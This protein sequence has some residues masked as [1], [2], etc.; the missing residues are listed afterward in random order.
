[1]NNHRFILQ[2]Y[3][4]GAEAV[5]V[6]LRAT[7]NAVLVA[8]STPRNKSRYLMMSADATMSRVAATISR[9]RNTLSV[10][11]RRSHYTPISQL[12]QHGEPSRPSSERRHR[13][14]RQR[15][16][17]RLCTDMRRTT[18]IFSSAPSSEPRMP[19]G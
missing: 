1:M 12:R 14:S 4:G 3:K 2:P 16:L 7:R 11:R 8:T 18:S 17:H 19:S 15:L 10:I 5:T 6:A 9:Q 13:S